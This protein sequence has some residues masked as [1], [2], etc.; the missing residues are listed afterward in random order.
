MVVK[1]CNCPRIDPAEWEGKEFDWE[2]KTFYFLPLNYLMY[3][4]LGLPEKIRQLRKYII[5]KNYSFSDFIPILCNWAPFKGRV[6]IQIKN[7][8][9]Y[10][11][12]IYTF[13]MGKVF[14]TVFQGPAKEFRQAVKDF[15]SQI[16]LN[17]GIPPQAV[18]V[19]YGHCKVCAKEKNHLAV[20][21]VKT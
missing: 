18:L 14:T 7:P 20:F 6:M 5:D 12:N 8:E 2:N 21:F 16:E 1:R 13:D 4:P 19:W 10:D 17:H 15:C 11:E 3:K 9:K